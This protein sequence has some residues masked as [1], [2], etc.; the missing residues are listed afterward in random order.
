MVKQDPYK[1][2]VDKASGKDDTTKDRKS[3][4]DKGSNTDDDDIE[5]ESNSKNKDVNFKKVQVSI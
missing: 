5:Y 3:D 2:K 1:A 4:T